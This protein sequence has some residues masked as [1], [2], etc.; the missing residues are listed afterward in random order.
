LNPRP[1]GYEHYDARLPPSP[2]FRPVSLTRRKAS[3]SVAGVS[4]RLPVPTGLVS[5]FVSRCA[6]WRTAFRVFAHAYL[7]ALAALC[8]CARKRCPGLVLEDRADQGTLACLEYVRIL[9]RDPEAL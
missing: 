9:E 2:V 5:K 1:L 4:H 6:S 3:V 7:G 8:S